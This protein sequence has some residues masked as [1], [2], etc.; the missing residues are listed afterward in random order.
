M[1]PVEDR[2]DLAP[3]P[4]KTPK[5]CEEDQ[6]AKI[7]STSPNPDKPELKNLITKARKYENTKKDF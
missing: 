3:T 1:Q 5:S 6:R 2:Q 7:S 4:S